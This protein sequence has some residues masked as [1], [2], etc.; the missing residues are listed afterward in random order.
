MVRRFLCDMPMQEEVRETVFSIEPESV[1]GSD[2]FGAFFYHT[3][4]D[5]VSEDLFGTVTEFFL[6]VAMPKSFTATT[7]SLIPKTDSP[8]SWSEYRRIS[9]CNVTNKICTKLMTIRLGRVLPKVLSLYQSG[10]VPGWLLRDNVLLAQELIHSLECRRADA[11]VI[12]KL[13]MTKAYDRVSWEFL[14]QVLRHKGFPKRWINL[15]AN[16]VSNCW[17]LVL[18]N[19]EH[20]G[21]FHSTGGLQQGDPLSPALFIL[22]ADYLSRGLDRLFVAHTSMY[23]QTP[24][25]IRVSH[26]PYADDM[27]IFTNICIQ[28]MELL[29]DFLRAYEWISGQMINDEK[30]SFI[31][32]RQIR[33]LL[34]GWAMM[35][36]S[37]GGRL[38]L[39]KSVLQATPLH[40]LQVVFPP[41]SV[42][43]AIERIFNGFFWDRTMGA[44]TSIGRPGKR[45]LHPTL[46]LYNRNH[47]TVWHR[48]C[49]IRDVAE[50]FI[51]WTLGNGLVSF[52]HDNWFSEKPL[53]Q[54]VHSESNTMEPVRYYWHEGEWNVP[55]V[56]RTIL[57]HIAHAICQIPIAA[58][59]DDKIV[60]TRSSDGVFST[61]AAW[62]AIRVA[63]PW[64]QLLVDI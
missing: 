62:E 46:V 9:L 2:G 11:N 54:L 38:A 24:G 42:L 59:Q 6:G 4:W 58:R 25:R 32:G 8:A 34:Q 61:R 5:F 17:F 23:Y 14:Y 10:F 55:K 39:I 64:W 50:P 60:W 16:T 13:D 41:K 47:S 52:W 3:C 22:A 26:L 30:S 37:H 18:V 57:K 31:V 33:G 28:N 44:S 21:F 29:R 40:L 19:G 35:N 27:M 43:I 15:E 1:A 12:F 7:I 63:S 36:L 51:L 49:H 20:A 48:L 53:A 45:N 56:F